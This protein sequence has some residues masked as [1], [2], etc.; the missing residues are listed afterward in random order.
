MIS[1]GTSCRVRVVAKSPSGDSRYA[2][3][4]FGMSGYSSVGSLGGGG[5]LGNG[6]PVLSDD[7]MSN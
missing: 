1:G 7:A 4:H 2:G 3:G 5:V 6:L